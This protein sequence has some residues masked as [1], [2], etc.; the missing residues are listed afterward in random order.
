MNDEKAPRRRADR[1]KLI[2]DS[3]R[4][5]AVAGFIKNAP[6]SQAPTFQR[7]FSGRSLAAGVK[8]KCLECCCFDRAE[9]RD[10][11]VLTCPLWA[12]RPFQIAAVTA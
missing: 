7:A 8:A 6:P 12:Y 2:P 3:P 9:I 5:V 1:P 4:G 11:L 10:C